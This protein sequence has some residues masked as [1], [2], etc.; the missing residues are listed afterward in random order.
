MAYILKDFYNEGDSGDDGAYG[1]RFLGQT[2]LTTS[3][4]LANRLGVLIRRNNTLA[5]NVTVSLRETSDGVPVSNT[6]ASMSIAFNDLSA[7]AAWTYFDLATPVALVNN[8]LYAIVITFPDGL[9]NYWVRWRYDAA[10]DTYGGG[11]R[12]F[13]TN[14]GANWSTSDTSDF[15]FEVYGDVTYVDMSATGGGT[16]GGNATLDTITSVNMSATGGGTGGGSVRMTSHVQMS[17][18]RSRSQLVTASND[19]IWYEDFSVAAGAMVE[20][21]AARDQIDTSDQLVMFSLFEKVFIVNGAKKKVADFGNV[22]ITTGAIGIPFPDRDIILTGGT[23]E[24]QMVVDYISSTTG[25]CTIYGKRTTAATFVDTEVVTGTNKDDEEV[26]FT[27]NADEDSGATVPGGQPHWYDWN[28]YGGGSNTGAYGALPEKVY[29]GCAYGGR[30][31]LSGNPDYPFQWYASRQDNPFEF[32]YVLPDAQA[33]KAGGTGTLGQLG[34][35]VRALIPWNDDALAFGC[36]GSLTVLR[37]NP[38][39]GGYMENIDSQVGVYGQ[40]AW[41]FDGEG[42]LY[43]W[44]PGGVYRSTRGF[45]PPTL[46]TAATYPDIV[47]DEAANPATHRISF[48]YDPRQNGVEIS[49]TKLSSGSNSCYWYDVGTNGFYPDK[50]DNTHGAYSMLFYD[51]NNPAHKHL[52]LGCKDGYVRRFDP[53]SKNDDGL[54]IDSFVDY[55]PIQLTQSPD[56]EGLIFSVDAELGGGNIG[57]IEADSNDV[58]WRLWVDKS[59]DRINELLSTSVTPNIGGT[60]KG[61]GRRRGNAIRRKVKG[62]YAGIKLKN[63][64]LGESWAFEKLIVGIRPAGRMK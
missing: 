61:P 56:H 17:N 19:Q 22:K 23:S 49:I 20:L 2:F 38:A 34:D 6:L 47:T 63:D 3:A 55:G 26:S 59:A 37:G 52:L 33:A 13:S 30:A 25:S 16:G 31:F 24:A 7:T 41:C 28:S 8:T 64:I 57:G 32:N 40:N 42:N 48:G 45:G 11:K 9:T 15:L 14:S 53:A 46:L 51:A 62:V 50:F 43:F 5:G 18:S 27:L 39:D 12:C 44:G 10:G 1:A 58:I 36:A 4:Y 21:I 54:A 60:F 29:L 35:I